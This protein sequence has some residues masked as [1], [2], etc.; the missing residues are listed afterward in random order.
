MLITDIPTETFNQ[1]LADL[2]ADGWRVVSEYNGFDA[3]IDYGSVVLRRDGET[4]TFEWTNW[5]EGEVYGPDALILKLQE[6]YDLPP[7]EE[8]KNT[9]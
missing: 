3:W 2:C 5:F 7:P 6:K 1:I 8:N 4:L 9:P